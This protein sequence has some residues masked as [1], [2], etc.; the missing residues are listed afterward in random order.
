MKLD[1]DSKQVFE[2]ADFEEEDDED[3]THLRLIDKEG[4]E[5]EGGESSKLL[6]LE[7]KVSQIKKI[8]FYILCLYFNIVE[9]LV[10]S[11]CSDGGWSLLPESI[12]RNM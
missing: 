1:C 4:T 5:A 3:K 7:Q 12:S 8:L 10:F 2:D 11:T 6:H 9:I